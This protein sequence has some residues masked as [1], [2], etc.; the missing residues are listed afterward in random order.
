MRPERPDNQVDGLTNCDALAWGRPVAHRN[1]DGHADVE[2]CDDWKTAHA[3]RNRL[4]ILTLMCAAPNFEQ[5]QVA[6]RRLTFVGR[7]S[8]SIGRGDVRSMQTCDSE[9]AVADEQVQPS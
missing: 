8:A 3:A 1:L 6:Q 7:Q 9:G 5:D 2:H 4:G